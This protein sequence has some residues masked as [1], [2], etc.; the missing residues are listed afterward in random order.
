MNGIKILATFMYAGL[1]PKAPGTAGTVAAIP[2]VLGA[3]LL[4]NIFYVGATIS[5]VIASIFICQLYEQQNQVHDSSEIVID[6]VAG[7]FVAMALLPI[8]FKAFVLAFII[9]RLFDILKPF[10]INYMDKNV[11]GGFGVVADDVLAGLFTNII[12]QVLHQ[13]WALL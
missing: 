9:F 10:P 4:G 12:L 5:L 1:S 7:F 8:S 13:K 2:F 3:A 11:Q 6:E